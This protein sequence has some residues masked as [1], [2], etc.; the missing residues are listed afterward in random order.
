L[1]EVHPYQL[2]LYFLDFDQ[3]ERRSAVEIFNPK[4]LNILAP[5]AIVR[6]YSHGKYLSFNFDQSVRLRINHVRGKNAALSG[7]F[8]D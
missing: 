3:Q 5:V 8:F 2:S 6:N 4:T 1:K 7:I